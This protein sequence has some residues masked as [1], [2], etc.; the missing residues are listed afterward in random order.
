MNKYMKLAF[1]EAEK[2]LTT[3]DVPVGAI[4]VENGKVI[5][6]AHNTKEKNQVVT[7]HAEINVIEKACRKKENWYLSE[8]ELYVTL[9]PCKMCLGAIEQA[10]IKKVIYAAPR[11]KKDNFKSTLK[12]QGEGLEEAQKLLKNFFEN[13][14]K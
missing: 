6:K 11:D 13:K 12:V 5:A 1:T 2:S 9:E 8:C 14:R 10:R 3:D 4:I 7:H